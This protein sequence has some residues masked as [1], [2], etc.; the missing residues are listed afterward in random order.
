LGSSKILIETLT[1]SD[2]PNTDFQTIGR[3][4]FSRSLLPESNGPPTSVAHFSSPA[5]TQSDSACPCCP[6]P[7]FS[8][9]MVVTCQPQVG[10]EN[11]KMYPRSS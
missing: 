5:K 1:H 7:P 10:Y 9:E 11:K 6:S 4:N 2:L 3:C 8:K